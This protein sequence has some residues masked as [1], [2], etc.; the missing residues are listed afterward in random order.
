MKRLAKAWGLALTLLLA[1]S[2]WRGGVE[3]GAQESRPES[4]TLLTQVADA[5]RNEGDLLDELAAAHATEIASLEATATA[6][7]DQLVAAEATSAARA[8][9]IAALQTQ[10]AGLEAE[11]GARTAPTGVEVG[12][13][14]VANAG[15]WDVTATGAELSDTIELDRLPEPAVAQGVF[16]LVELEIVNAGTEAQGYDPTWFRI[17]DDRGRSWPFD[18]T[19]TDNLALAGAG[20]RQYQAIQPG[21][22]TT[23]V[24]VFDI[25]PDATG[26]TL[27]TQEDLSATR[28]PQPDPFTIRL[29]E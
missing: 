13:G 2:V 24:V 7:D 18:F 5:H 1:L 25:A 8:T 23:A 14:E 9:E 20:A 19:Q 26:L 29:E 6:L 10:V 17:A 28:E 15:P 21:I 12:L 3:S 4:E 16:L 11:L 22:P 27:R